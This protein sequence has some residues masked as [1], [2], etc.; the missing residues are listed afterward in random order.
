MIES[1]LAAPRRD[2]LYLYCPQIENTISTIKSRRDA[3]GVYEYATE[4][5]GAAGFRHQRKIEN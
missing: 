4:R 2:L 5:G 3:L 1:Q